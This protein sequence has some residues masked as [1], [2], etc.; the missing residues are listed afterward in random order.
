MDGHGGQLELE[1]KLERLPS[2]D[3]TTTA[4]V[5]TPARVAR[6]IAINFAWIAKEY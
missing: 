1:L 4:S 2:H 5:L 3:G 6:A